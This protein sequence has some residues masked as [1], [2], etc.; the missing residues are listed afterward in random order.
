AHAADPVIA[1]QERESRGV[2]QHA[3]LLAVGA[4]GQRLD[5]FLPTAPDMAS[6]PAPELELAVDPER[7]APEPQLKAHAL[8]AHPP[9]RVEA[10]RNQDFAEVGVAAIFGEPPDVVEI[11]LGSVGADIDILQFVVV[12]VGDQLREIVKAVIDDAE[13]ATGKG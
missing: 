12:D 4:R 5:Q 2:V 13:G 11:L 1:L 8:L 7:L 10:S 6:K 3:D 9:G